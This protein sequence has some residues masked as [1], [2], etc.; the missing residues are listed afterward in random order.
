MAIWTLYHNPQ[1]SKSR[2]A[3]KLIESSGVTF[4]VVEYLKTPLTREELRLLIHNLKS[5]LSELV[6]VK[7]AEFQEN[8]FDINSE[9]LVIE[10]LAKTPR[11]LERPLLWGPQGVVI[12]RPTERITE[13]LGLN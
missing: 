13:A 12:G 1:C 11:L 5:P 8:P 9:E 4:T 10:H 2:E 6:R 3:L 7:E